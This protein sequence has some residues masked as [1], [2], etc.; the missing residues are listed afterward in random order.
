M[1]LK[2]KNYYKRI[3]LT[4][5]F[6]S[7]IKNSY[8]MSRIL[9]LKQK[10]C[11]KSTY[12]N[13]A[14]ENFVTDYCS[15]TLN[16]KLGSLS[17]NNFEEL[18]V[19]D[20]INQCSLE[21]FDE[22]VEVSESQ[23]YF[24]SSE[25]SFG[26][27][28][29]TKSRT[30]YSKYSLCV[31]SKKEVATS[32]EQNINVFSQTCSHSKISE[33]S[34][35]FSVRNV[36]TE[37]EK[38]DLENLIY[39]DVEVSCSLENSFL[40][41]K[42]ASTEVSFKTSCY[43][44][45]TQTKINLKKDAITNY[46]CQSLRKGDSN[47]KQKIEQ[48]QTLENMETFEKSLKDVVNPF[49]ISIDNEYE[50]SEF[51]S[52]I[53]NEN[54]CRISEESSAVDSSSTEK[55]I[56]Q[57][58]ETKLQNI[59]GE[60]QK[61]LVS[62][63]EVF[64]D[65][66][67]DKSSNEFS[68]P[69]LNEVVEESEDIKK[70]E[71]KNNSK[72]FLDSKNKKSIEIEK[73]KTLE[74]KNSEVNSVTKSQGVLSFLNFDNSCEVTNKIQEHKIYISPQVKSI[75]KLE[76]TPSFIIFYDKN[77]KIP[78]AKEFSKKKGG[79]ERSKIINSKNQISTV[80]SSSKTKKEKV[81]RA[82]KNCKG[83]W[84]D[85]LNLNS[86][87][88]LT[89]YKSVED[90]EL[91]K[92]NHDFLCNGTVSPDLNSLSRFMKYHIKQSEK[93]MADSRK[94]LPKKLAVATLELATE[95]AQHLYEGVVNCRQCL[96]SHRSCGPINEKS[97]RGKGKRP[98]EESHK[99]DDGNFYLKISAKRKK[100]AGDILEND[101]NFTAEENNL[102]KEDFFQ[103]KKHNF[104]TIDISNFKS[105]TLKRTLQEI[106]NSE[107]QFP[108]P[109][110]RDVMIDLLEKVEKNLEKENIEVIN[111]E[112]RDKKGNPRIEYEHQ[113]FW[114]TNLLPIIYIIGA[115]C[116]LF[117]LCFHSFILYES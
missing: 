33:A 7:N 5:L 28:N 109:E 34:Q 40:S 77:E 42:E 43:E 19:K 66:V 102:R 104:L 45:E 24:Q 61:D 86:A 94:L 90:S 76:V 68:A 91:L 75:S 98:F 50:N 39:T 25:T 81:C 4:K 84:R 17:E 36:Y 13:K 6:I 92:A 52:F 47:E 103:K 89:I 23:E 112:K 96:T 83:K 15:K 70:E 37:T 38:S 11:S 82:C 63:L 32:P 93:F 58:K 49:D 71:I 116:S 53:E 56:Y 10:G 22:K 111:P 18:E 72:V 9:K 97:L 79:K 99:L 65:L 69:D 87:S 115:I 54:R 20:A 110:I 117:F 16:H 80:K 88:E 100:E 21:S 74:E 85:S 57:S 107:T 26:S 2:G 48:D 78:N 41:K 67:V 114:R 29:V 55:Q 64:S 12:F 27:L 1:K 44:V 30:S 35:A 60:S 8:S 3:F 105:K 113:I 59:K 108:V 106:K 46:D 95:R 101:V 73:N 31:K 62:K 14:E 51:D